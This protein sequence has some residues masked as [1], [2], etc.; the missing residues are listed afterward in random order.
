MSTLSRFC[1]VY[2]SS[3]R[4]TRVTVFSVE[5][6]AAVVANLT[7]LL[8]F[9]VTTTNNPQCIRE[10]V[11][12]VFIPGFVATIPSLGLLCVVLL[13]LSGFSPVI[14]CQ[15]EP[16]L[17]SP[18]VLT[19]PTEFPCN[20]SIQFNSLLLMCR[21]NSQTANYRHSTV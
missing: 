3:T 9:A 13:P 6:L 11:K 17:S 10:V 8:A 7:S 16:R 20:N 1:D 21:V 18:Q 2:V 12:D 19:I 5:L 15:I 4:Y 14:C